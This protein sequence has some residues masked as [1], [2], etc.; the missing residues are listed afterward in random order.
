M[1]NR[2]PKKL[3]V[4]IALTGM[5][6][7]SAPV[8]AIPADCYGTISTSRTM[9][10]YVPHDGDLNITSS[11]SV[12]VVAASMASSV[13]A[14]VATTSNGEFSGS[15]TNS[16]LVSASGDAPKVVG[17][18]TEDTLGED[19][20]I[21]NKAS[22]LINA[23][24]ATVSG[25]AYGIEI[26]GYAD[27]AITNHGDIVAGVEVTT[28]GALGSDLD[29]TAIGIKIIEELRGTL[30]NHG[31]ILAKATNTAT[32]IALLDGL[33]FLHDLTGSLHN[34]G[35]ISAQATKTD[36]NARGIRLL[37]LTITGSITNAG[38]ISAQM[39]NV[40]GSAEGI[41]INSALAGSLENSGQ[42]EASAN[43]AWGIRVGSSLTGSLENDGHITADA[44]ER[45]WGVYVQQ[46]L[47]GTLEN[48]GHIEANA[49]TSATGVY[50][51]ILADYDAGNGA[52]FSNQGTILANESA[53]YPYAVHVNNGADGGEIDTNGLFHNS[54]ELFGSVYL[55]GSGNTAV[56]MHHSGTWTLYSKNNLD[57]GSGGSISGNYV[58]SG[59]GLIQVGVDDLTPVAGTYGT[60]NV[61]GTA[62]FSGQTGQPFRVLAPNGLFQNV[63]PGDVLTDVFVAGSYVDA[64]APGTDVGNGLWHWEIIDNEV[65]SLVNGLDF[66][67]IDYRGAVNV[68]NGQG[69]GAYAGMG[70]VIDA[71]EANPAI[72]GCEGLM[73][74]FGQ[75]GTQDDVARLAAQASPGTVV[76]SFNA[77]QANLLAVGNLVGDRLDQGNS[78]LAQTR[79]RQGLAAG[80]GD[81]LNGLWIRPY[82]VDTKQD[83]ADNGARGYD[84]DTN[85]I[86]L[87]I[88]RLFADC[89]RL[90]IGLG[91]A[92]TDLDGRGALHNNL[93]ESKTWQVLAYGHREFADQIY[94]DLIG[95]IGWADN[96]SRRVM[97]YDTGTTAEAPVTA[98]AQGD[99]DSHFAHLGATLGK[100]YD[101]S[102]CFSLVPEL[103]L[104]YTYYDQDSFRESGAG[105]WNLAVDGMD[106]DILTGTFDLNGNYNTHLGT[107]ELTFSG[108]AG[109]GYD[110]MDADNVVD[111][112]LMSGAGGFVTEGAERDRLGFRGGVG[113][114]SLVADNTDVSINYDVDL[115]SD[116]MSQMGSVNLRYNF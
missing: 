116:Y 103:G 18:K 110:F 74:V 101:L 34:S 27:G 31:S 32:G 97:T 88:D 84:A 93:V 79:H 51:D 43:N 115:R 5:A 94:L 30:T 45:A 55:G 109:V 68:I 53:D 99:F 22:G 11:G 24:S 8:F 62:D 100:A 66:Q 78:S 38:H 14:V 9:T 111:A 61:T 44:S 85:G 65:G 67:F 82:H 60:V 113:V 49:T 112:S 13:T 29:R 40:G 114:R 50:I 36:G 20:S 19:A 70:G 104:A 106:E 28:S 92:E 73:A 87:G 108:Y 10:C 57:T 95:S 89:W 75:L 69:Y 26:R 64:P 21:T 47:N 7:T 39:S 37:N 90:G 86:L 105:P 15:I 25:A 80:D 3:A 77:S 72:D 91:F 6:L 52:I 83:K 23:W 98:R 12:E 102:D 42:I 59:D 16:G 58:Q 17:I 48:N 71:C 2:T 41:F 33:N 56:D 96:D 81:T 1:H 46:T 4:A 35:T 76:E 63:Q 107:S 54:G